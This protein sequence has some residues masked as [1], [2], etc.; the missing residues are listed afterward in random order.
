VLNEEALILVGLLVALGLLILGIWNQLSPSSRPQVRRSASTGSPPKPEPEAE[1]VLVETPFA[2]QLD[3]VAPPPAAEP[4]PGVAPAADQGWIV[5]RCRTLIADGRFEDAVSTAM[6]VLEQ[7][8]TAAAA[9][10]S[11]LWRQV[12]AARD[13]MGDREGALTAFRTAIEA[14]PES[15]RAGLRQECETWASI[16]ARDLLAAVPEEGDRY[17]PLVAA[18]TFVESAQ[19][20]VQASPPLDAARAE[21]DVAFWPA[22]ET[23]VRTLIADRDPAEAYRLATEALSDPALPPPRRPTFEE[24]RVETLAARIIVL[25]ERAVLAVE[26][27]REWEAVGALERG[28]TLLRSASS[29]P[30]DRRDDA[31]AR[32]AAAYA[33][34]GA[35]RV[36][37]GE[38]EDA[39]DP[40]LRSLRLSKADTP[41][42]DE[43]RSAMVKALQGVVES[44]VEIIRDV[45]ATGNTESAAAQAEKIWT[46]LRAGIA[47]GVPQEPLN[48]AIATARRLIE[49]LG[50]APS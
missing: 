23:H 34:L 16:V 22:Y 40:L 47:A 35:H 27:S 12:A 45:A 5:D 26:E 44:R 18:R 49:E 13:R 3:L 19:T 38:F 50:A 21:L 2:A 6:I 43:A 42:R 39:V 14:A 41:A 31:A 37:A 28:E 10:T 20:L 15:D 17:A 7:P 1:E 33:R 8:D 29:L 24:F 36:D 25:A 32:L 46:L 48:G 4:A 9:L 11:P 30:A